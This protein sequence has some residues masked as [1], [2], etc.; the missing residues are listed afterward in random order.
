MPANLFYNA[1]TNLI[2]N[3]FFDENNQNK[4]KI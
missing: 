1:N 4:T 2:Q 3:Y